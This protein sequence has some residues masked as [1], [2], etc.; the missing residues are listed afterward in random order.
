[1]SHQDFKQFLHAELI[2][3]G[4]HDAAALQQGLLSIGGDAQR[5]LPIQES[6]YRKKLARHILESYGRH[7][8][9]GRPESL[10]FVAQSNFDKLMLDGPFRD[11]LVIIS[12]GGPDGEQQRYFVET[13][14][15]V[16]RLLRLRRHN[17][18][19]LRTA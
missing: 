15:S 9:S 5:S 11:L 2:R 7:T 13:P 8:A 14:D 18:T 4:G 6:E 12:W 10:E 17:L 16:G 1:M 3:L 19:T